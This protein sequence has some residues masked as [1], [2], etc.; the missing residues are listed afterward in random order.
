[1][2]THPHPTDAGDL[3]DLIALTRK[4]LRRTWL[5]SG[6]ALLIVAAVGWLLTAAVIDLIAPMPVP[7]RV[8]AASV[9]WLLLVGVLVTAV[10]WPWLRPLRDMRVARLIEAVVPSI[11]NRLISSLDIH[12][13]HAGNGTTINRTFYE[14]LLTDTRTR[15]EQ[16]RIDM[17]ADPRKMVRSS[18]VAGG[19]LLLTIVL[20][21]LFHEA[22]PSAL[23]RVL[24]PTAPIPPVSHLRIASPGDLSAL[25]GDPLRVE[26]T[27]TRGDTDTLIIKLKP[28][29]G[30]WVRYPMTKEADGS[31]VFAF[32]GLQESYT[33]QIEGGGTWT[34]PHRI[35]A[36]RRPVIED[37]VASVALP[38]YMGLPELQPVPLDAGQISVPEGGS[39]IVSAAVGQ[40]PVTG[41]ALLMRPQRETRTVTDERET[42]WFDDRPPADARVLL[43]A[44]WVSQPVFSGTAALLLDGSRPSLSFETRLNQLDV[45]KNHSLMLYLRADPHAPPSSVTIGLRARNQKDAAT[46]TLDADALTP[47]QWV[48]V[49]RSIREMGVTSYRDDVA[50]LYGFWVKVE[51]GRVHVDRVGSLQR[52]EREEQLTTLE[53]ADEVTLT[54][55]AQ[56][57]RWTGRIPVDQDTMFALT[58]ANA[59]GHE[60]L[61]MEPLVVVAT[62][63]QPPTVI[64]EKPGRSLTL[65]AIEPVPVVV[66][67]IDDYG[68]DA[69]GIAYGSSREDFAQPQWLR[70]FE[71]PQRTQ[72]AMMAIDPAARGLTPGKSI[73]YRMAVRDRKGQVT[74]SP[75]ME[76]T[77]AQQAQP[78][79]EATRPLSSS[80]LEGLSRLLDVQSRIAQLPAELLA[81]LQLTPEGRIELTPDASL[82]ATQLDQLKELQSL[83]QQQKEMLDKLRDQFADA[84]KEAQASPLATL[85]EAEALA[86][87]QQE[88]NDLAGQ[89]SPLS[90]EDAA[91]LADMQDQLEAMNAARSELG[92]NPDAAQQQ[93]MDALARLQA[94][95]TAQQLSRLGDV[96]EAQKQNLE[97][98][99]QQMGQLQQQAQA[100][101]D[102]QA[103][104]Q[105]SQQQQALDP[106][107]LDAMQRAQDL[108]DAGRMAQQDAMPPAPWTPPGREMEGHPVEQD[109]PEENP[110][111]NLAQQ[112]QP[113][114]QDA[115]QAEQNWWDQPVDTPPDAVT[116]Q[117][118]ERFADRQ[119]PVDQPPAAA[120][121]GQQ[122]AAGQQQ[123]PEAQQQGDFQ[124]PLTQNSN[125]QQ[126]AAGP[127]AAQTPRQMLVSHQGQMQ[128]ALQQSAQGLSDAQQQLGQLAQQMQA[129][130]QSPGQLPGLMSSPEMAAA[131]AMAQAA[132]AQAQ[133]GQPGPSGQADSM[134]PP[135]PGPSLGP[136]S[137]QLRAGTLIV[138]DL[139]DLPPDRRATLYR[140]PAEVRQ[141]IIRGMTEKGPDGYQPLIDAYFRSLLDAPASEDV[142]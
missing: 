130:A 128:E 25:Q 108:L 136:D 15:L 5:V 101:A 89:G 41:R 85:P 140:L 112:G 83:M 87:M 48:R 38:D 69:V 71:Q 66:R 98:L 86:A 42:V 134:M 45:H 53:P 62:K 95:Q 90:P 109:T 129:A 67:A 96:L 12:Q 22:M 24:R 104:D 127:P 118:S 3:T 113:Q 131:A 68:V 55:D 43:D 82:D 1:M 50:S 36:L 84:A 56:T 47:G 18:I 115:A 92:Q 28:R 91:A 2:T 121:Q 7:M 138:A 80:L 110:R 4:R 124:Q 8:L 70:S 139:A 97:N 141:P 106:Q 33:Y 21:L 78:A 93:M 23:A 142:P 125:D 17:V 132:A 64:V 116:L 61:A 65:Q 81:N 137:L 27:L 54:L 16:F 126:Q 31:F 30:Q 40:E 57:N 76:I 72:L 58:F 135:T 13:R 77:L 6:V 37:V 107:A 44:T 111:E 29:D 19:V 75:T 117:Q 74:L 35:T 14:R 120:E 46:W 103:L 119:R 123:Q 94:Q 26:A 99:A 51:G 11:K 60:S 34:R 10:L 32:G 52:R 39:V 73:F 59:H 63:D 79:T 105:V 9:F 88:L 100:A 102:A 133:Q 20:V 114:G 49:D 122:Q